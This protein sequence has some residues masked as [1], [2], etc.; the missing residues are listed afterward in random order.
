MNNKLI[1]LV[2]TLVVGVI[3]AGTIL[4]PAINDATT[5]TTTYTNTNYDFEVTSSIDAPI[6]YTLGDNNELL[7]NGTALELASGVN[8]AGVSSTLF[9][10]QYVG[11]EGFWVTLPSAVYTNKVTSMTINPDGSWSITRDGTDITNTEGAEGSDIYAVVSEGER[12]AYRPSNPVNFIAPAGEAIPF[13]VNYGQ[14][15]SGGNT[16]PLFVRANLLDGAIVDE[17]A[18][19]FVNGEK[20]DID[21]TFS[22][23]SSSSAVVSDG[24]T[25][26]TNWNMS[27]GADGYNLSGRYIALPLKEFEITSDVGGAMDLLKVIPIF[28]IIALVV[29][30]VSVVT[31]PR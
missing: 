28:V 27:M 14:A 22:I 31:R 23:S 9:G 20:V 1:P 26:Y 15:V 29:A 3:L 6:T 25:T 30:T 13:V 21:V 16:Y 12:V 5:K 11:S 10:G 8:Y 19:I 24:I 2:I 17:Y 18:Y 4:V 7:I